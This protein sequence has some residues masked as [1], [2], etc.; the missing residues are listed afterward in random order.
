[1]AKTLIGYG[2]TN[3][4]GVATLDYDAEGH[5]LA[6]SGYVA[7]TVGNYILTAETEIDGETYTSSPSYLTV[8]PKPTPTITLAVNNNSITYGSTITL[9]G[10]ISA[11]SGLSV[12][13]YNGTTLVD[14]LTTGTNGTFTKTVTGLSV[15][16]HTFKAV[17]EGNA[18]YANAE[19]STVQV[20][21]NKL[22]TSLEI[23]VPLS[24]VY[25]DSFN[26]TGTLMDTTNNT[27]MNNATVKL[28][29]GNTV[30]DTQTTN[31][32]GVVSFT[33]T[34]VSMGT[35][36]FKL[37]YEG[38]TN[39]NNTE[40]SVVTRDI[41]KETTVL[42]LTSPLDNYSTYTDGTITVTGTL[43]TDDGEAINNKSIIVFENGTTLTTL[44]TG[45]DGAFTGSV[46]G[47][48]AGNH[49]L[50]V[51]FATDT[52]YTASSVNRTVTLNSPTLTLASDKSILSYADSE[53]AT[54]TATY[55]GASVN[56][57][58]IT[59]EVRK[60]SDDS[61]VETLTGTTNS[62]GIATVS[63]LGQGAGDLYIRAMYGMLVTET[64]VSDCLK[65][66]ATTSDNTSKYDLNNPAS[67]L[68]FDTDH[69]ISTSN[70]TTGVSNYLNLITP[71]NLP[72]LSNFSIECDIK[73]VNGDYHSIFGLMFIDEL[74]IGSPYLTLELLNYNGKH[75]VTTRSPSFA[76]DN[77]V[78]PA[79]S[80]N[81]W[82]H[83]K[84]EVN[85][86]SVTAKITTGDNPSYYS[87]TFTTDILSSLNYLGICQGD[88]NNTV[89]WKNL[90]IKA[91]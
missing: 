67:V 5:E 1:M 24:L 15:G 51:A 89:H 48:S 34:P 78:S 12:K 36:S 70:T 85:G 35:H 86:N 11:G 46:S 74:T 42:T 80:A 3:E 6:E 38:A 27:A 10:T 16:N 58:S 50:N 66:D 8:N 72:V 39:Y 28:K 60:Q 43:L 59:F 69:Y 47:L 20:T 68:T 26:I 55:T 9:N 75:G 41:N 61:L 82:Y 21:V 87:T 33:Q 71:K 2:Y 32:N 91:L 64:Y 18:S 40:S 13:I 54:L 4:N 22:N 25:S 57:K 52:N 19:S 49:T 83:F 56:N 30:V 17:F 44:T 73:K 37:V 79:L 45:N 90:K 65:Y 29:V 7:D 53:S 62:S 23:S 88:Y 77:R 84:L 63:Y 14:T 76:N 81:V 31:S